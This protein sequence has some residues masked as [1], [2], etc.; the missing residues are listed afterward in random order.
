MGSS[1]IVV[2]EKHGKHLRLV[3]Y[4]PGSSEVWDQEWSRYSPEAV[5]FV[6]EYYRRFLERP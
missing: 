5:R 1:Q 4:A 2:R 3:S 6:K